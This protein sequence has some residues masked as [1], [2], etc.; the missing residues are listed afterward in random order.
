MA[1]HGLSTPSDCYDGPGP[2]RPARPWG[3]TLPLPQLEGAKRKETVHKFYLKTL[4]SIQNIND[5]YQQFTTSTR[6]V[7]QLANSLNVEGQTVSRG[8]LSLKGNALR[9]YKQTS[10]NAQVLRTC[11]AHHL[12]S[13]AKKSN[14]WHSIRGRLYTLEKRE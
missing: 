8:P 5:H 3:L 6:R 14:C 1:P 9:E 12:K 7:D 2:L 10:A 11:Q 4:H 13:N